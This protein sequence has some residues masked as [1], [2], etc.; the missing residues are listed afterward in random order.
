MTVSGNWNSAGAKIDAVT[1]AATVDFMGTGQTL[2]DAGSNNGNG[3]VFAKVL[4]QGSGTKTLS[5]GKFSVANNGLLTM[6]GTA[7][8]ASGAI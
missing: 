4:F 3:V 8:L 2:T 5:S 1:N 7:T 6:A